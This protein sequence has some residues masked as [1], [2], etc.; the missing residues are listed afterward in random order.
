MQ[1][2]SFEVGGEVYP[3]ASIV[4]FLQSK[5]FLQIPRHSEETFEVE[6]LLVDEMAKGVGHQGGKGGSASV[7]S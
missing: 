2:V 1:L 5:N 4:G 6:G 3:F 7:E